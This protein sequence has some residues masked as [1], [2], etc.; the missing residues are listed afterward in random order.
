MDLQ[1]LGDEAEII[2]EEF[3]PFRL[4]GR[5]ARGVETGG[6]LNGYNGLNH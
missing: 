6:G 2:L 3:K 1:D 5:P 4:L